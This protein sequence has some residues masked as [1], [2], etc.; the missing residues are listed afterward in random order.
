VYLEPASNLYPKPAPSLTISNNGNPI[1]PATCN[2][3][4]LSCP[5]W[6]FLFSHPLNQ[7]GNSID[8]SLKIC[9]ESNFFKKSLL[10]LTMVHCQCFSMQKSEWFC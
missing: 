8:C 6:F 4:K 10:S 1:H 3:Q 9:L 5:P 7:L 2:G